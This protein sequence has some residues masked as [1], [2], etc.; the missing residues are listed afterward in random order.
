MI[1]FFLH[2]TKQSD[3]ER[4]QNCP[5]KQIDLVS[6]PLGGV[7]LTQGDISERERECGKP[8]AQKYLQGESSS[9]AVGSRQL[10]HDD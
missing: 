10:E 2:P 3:V 7:A 6:V 9:V 4:L 1:A 5:A 8:K